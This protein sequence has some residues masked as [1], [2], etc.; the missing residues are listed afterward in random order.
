[1]RRNQRKNTRIQNLSCLQCCIYGWVPTGT[2]GRLIWYMGSL[3]TACRGM[4]EGRNL[5]EK[6]W[7]GRRRVEIRKQENEE[8][9]G[10][11][12]EYERKGGEEK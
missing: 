1:M 4:Q 10:R 9:D 8:G 6:D 7:V 2:W 5:Q 3:P 12:S 11:R